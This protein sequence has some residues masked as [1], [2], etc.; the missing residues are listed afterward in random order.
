MEER[1]SERGYPAIRVS[2]EYDCD[3]LTVFRAYCD[4][5]NRKLYDGNIDNVEIRRQYG[6]GLYHFYQKFNRILVVAT[7]ELSVIMLC[8]VEEDGSM[9][10][11]IYDNEFD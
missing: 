8:N 10:I 11:T 1:A 2:C 5:L 9:S 3:A 4:P 6:T 7:R